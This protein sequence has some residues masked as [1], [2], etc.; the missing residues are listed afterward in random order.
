[1]EILTP[2]Y[3]LFAPILVW[4]VE[5]LFPYPYIVEELIKAVI[6]FFSERDSTASSSSKIKLYILAGVFFALSE[7]VLYILNFSAV[8]RLDY[9]LIRF[10]LTSFL[11]T[12]TFL[13]MYAST[14]KN[15]KW[16]PLGFIL[17]VL[18]HYIFNLVLTNY[19]FL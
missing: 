1:M 4:P 7:T 18:I 14:Y 15:L 6:V 17:A 16:L 12:T 3:A 10:V 8:G 19:S 11:H 13:V 2:L 9:L 5:L